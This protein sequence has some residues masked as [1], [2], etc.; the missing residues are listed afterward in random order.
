MTFSKRAY[1]LLFAMIVL[2]IVQT[3]GG[4]QFEPPPLLD[5]DP[6]DFPL[7][8]PDPWDD[9]FDPINDLP[10]PEV[11][12]FPPEF[13]GDPFDDQFPLPDPPGLEDPFPDL[14]PS[15]F[16]GVLDSGE[17]LGYFAPPG[18]SGPFSGGLRAHASVATN[19]VTPLMQFPRRIWFSPQVTTRAAATRLS[20]SATYQTQILIP[21]SKRNSVA[22]MNTCPMG[23]V[24]HVPVGKKPISAIR[25]PGGQLALVSNSDDGT[26]SVLNVASK[27]VSQTISLPPVGGVPARP[28]GI[29]IL[30][31]GT[32]AYV[33]DHV[34]LPGSVVYIIDLTTMRAT[35]T[36][37]PVGDFPASVAVTPDGSQLW[38]SSWGSGRVDVF[39]T[40]TNVGVAAFNV[41]SPNGVAF[42][43]TGTRA[44]IASGS[45][46]G[47]IYVFDVQTLQSVTQ[48]AVGNLPH[49]VLVTPTGRHVFVN[50]VLSNSISQIDT[51]TNKVLRTIALKGKHPVGLTFIGKSPF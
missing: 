28:S 38:V 25:I 49:A 34:A 35:G 46:P 30:P 29:S 51:K 27:A 14:E 12:D 31:D 6:I 43:P 19:V 20:C 9:P 15:L 36:T 13:D 17:D 50:N 41:P 23:I 48:I 2:M 45:S 37:L 32:R 33:A 10:V 18:P 3:R 8:P 5:P 22:Y 1:F 44:Y 4:D 21:E 47:V 39:D 26:I 16:S 11:P 40:L 24:A 7:D 42:N